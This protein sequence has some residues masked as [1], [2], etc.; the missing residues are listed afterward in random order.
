MNVPHDGHAE[1]PVRPD[2]RMHKSVTGVHVSRVR[3]VFAP[4]AQGSSGATRLGRAAA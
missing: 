1:V 4:V 2:A 3:M